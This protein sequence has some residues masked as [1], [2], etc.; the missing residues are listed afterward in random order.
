MVNEE[1]SMR[2]ILM[3]AALIAGAFAATATTAAPVLNIGAHPTF[4]GDAGVRYR[5]FSN[6]GAE[7]VYLGAGDLGV[8]G[9]RVGQHYTWAS[10]GAFNFTFTVDLA[11]N[12]I[13]SSLPGATT[14]TRA[15][16]ADPVINAFRIFVRDDATAVNGVQA[17]DIW[18]TN[19]VVNGT[20]LGTVTTKGQTGFNAFTVTGVDVGTLYTLSGTIN[21]FGTMSTSQEANRIE[22]T[23]G[24]VPPIPVPAALP[25]LLAGLGGLVVVARRRKAA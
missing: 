4:T 7:E 11:N 12:R 1:F 25:L 16:A 13:S 5:S 17:G 3:A 24:Y 15:Y 10:P 22:I 18:L 9:N 21:L 14:L 2:R 8:G 23:A 20:S 6:T 19:L